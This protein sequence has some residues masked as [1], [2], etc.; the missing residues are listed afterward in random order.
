MMLSFSAFTSKFNVFRL[1]L[2]SVFSCGNVHLDVV[3]GGLFEVVG[4]FYTIEYRFIFIFKFLNAFIEILKFLG[5]VK[6][7]FDFSGVAHL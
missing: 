6:F 2:I 5:E 7:I 4:L 1:V 3:S